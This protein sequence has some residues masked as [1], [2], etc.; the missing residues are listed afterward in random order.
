MR[1]FAALRG[2][3]VSMLA[4]LFLVLAGTP[5]NAASVAG[6]T[7]Q[8]FGLTG[9]LAMLLLPALWM[10]PIFG[11][12]STTAVRRTN[13]EDVFT[14]TSTADADTT[15]GNIAHAMG[16]IPEVSITPILQAPAALSLW[17]ATT[18]DVTNVA[19]TKGT[20]AGSGN[21]AAQVRIR[22]NRPR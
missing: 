7:V 9:I 12:V 21:A 1:T 19:F 18:I 16:C 4:I 11:A 6:D 20:G 13:D 10:L 14:I 3:V 22:L 5:V 17:A 8:S 2:L 15:T